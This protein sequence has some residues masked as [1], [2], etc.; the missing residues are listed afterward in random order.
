M[1]GA[2]DGGA[3]PDVRYHVLFDPSDPVLLARVRWPD[4][5]E[6]ISAARPDWQSDP[7][8][9]DI[10]Y[11][12]SSTEITAEA[13]AELAARW[14]A[15]LPTPGP[16]RRPGPT[17]IRRM[18]ANWSN[19]SPAEQRAWSLHLVRPVR[20]SGR[21]RWRRRRADVESPKGYE[22]IEAALAA[23]LDLDADA[24]VVID[25]TEA[26]GAPHTDTTGGG[27]APVTADET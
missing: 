4:V 9:F 20:G 21:S 3:L 12:P 8:V 19:P 6:A 17:L 25:L 7:G 2:R 5:Y 23:V 18:P 13:A 15:T 26:G 14:G 1:S 16:D 10:P 22:P 11:D 27:G 24:D